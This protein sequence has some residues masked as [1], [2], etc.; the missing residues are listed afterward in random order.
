MPRIMTY[1]N[2]AGAPLAPG[3][4]RRRLRVG[5]QESESLTRTESESLSLA[6]NPSLSL[7]H[8]KDDSDDAAGA[9]RDAVTSESLAA[10]RSNSDPRRRRVRSATPA[11]RPGEPRP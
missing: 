5:I 9:M 3:R 10:A 7:A 1:R 6:R 4:A 2:R 11:R 8:H